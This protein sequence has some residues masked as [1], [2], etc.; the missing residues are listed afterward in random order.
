MNKS[1]VFCF[2][3]KTGV[4]I[5]KNRNHWPKHVLERVF[6]IMVVTMTC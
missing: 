6:V 4:R 2:R 5:M 1:R 3:R